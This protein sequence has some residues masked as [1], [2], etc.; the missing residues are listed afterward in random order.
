MSW[1]T[2]HLDEIARVMGPNRVRHPVH[3]SDGGEWDV[4]RS[5]PKSTRRTLTGARYLTPTGM[6]PDVAAEVICAQTRCDTTC[7]AMEWYV[8]TALE[9]IK[10][11]R[12]LAYDRRTHALAQRQG[13][14][15]YHQL[16]TF[17][18]IEQGYD[19]YRQMRRAK[20]WTG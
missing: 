13:Y 15:T 2:I 12:R 20:G 1:R 19:T 11:R 9:A 8:E 18:A 4:L 16:R 5:L 10:E 17:Q 7:E 6:L 3:G 14:R